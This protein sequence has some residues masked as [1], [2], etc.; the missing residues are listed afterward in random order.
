M[1]RPEIRERNAAIA[2]ALSRSEPAW[3]LA[4]RYGLT[5]KHVRNLAPVP[6]PRRP[7][8]EVKAGVNVRAWAGGLTLRPED[9][10]GRRDRT[11]MP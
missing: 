2:E 6:L 5:I 9:V 3:Q 10:L 7:W 4:D 1:T 11:V 8:R